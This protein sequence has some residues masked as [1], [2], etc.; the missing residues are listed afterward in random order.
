MGGFFRRGEIVTVDEAA[1]RWCVDKV[2]DGMHRGE[3]VQIATLSDPDRT[4]QLQVV[5]DRL[6]KVG[7]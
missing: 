7:G 4:M 3:A 1:K 5:T 2:E 6:T